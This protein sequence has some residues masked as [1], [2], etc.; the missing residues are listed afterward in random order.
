M[1]H[2][3]SIATKTTGRKRKGCILIIPVLLLAL[4]VSCPLLSV[5]IRRGH[6][7][8]P[9]IQQQLGPFYLI[10]QT[11]SPPK[12]ETPQCPEYYRFFN[13]ASMQRNGG[14]LSMS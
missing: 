6:I 11:N 10:A 13:S 8:P 7:Q 1:D 2:Y 9:N 3:R 5:G 14:M 12:C 4:L